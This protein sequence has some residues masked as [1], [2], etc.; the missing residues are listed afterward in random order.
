[1]D[2]NFNG[3]DDSHRISYAPN[4]TPRPSSARRRKRLS[5]LPNNVTIGAPRLMTQFSVKRRRLPTNSIPQS[6]PRPFRAASRLNSFDLASG[7]RRRITLQ[8]M[9]NGQMQQMPPFYPPSSSGRFFDDTAS[10]APPSSSSRPK[11]FSTIPGSQRIPDPRL[12]RGDRSYQAKMQK[13]LFDYLTANK[14]DIHMKQQL[15]AR[16]LRSPT[17]K[18]F[19]LMFQFL[20][21]RIDPGYRFVRSSE[22]DIYSILKFL[23]YPYLGNITKSQLGAV[24][25]T[26]WPTFLAMLHWIMQLVQQV[27]N[28]D[29]I[30][31][32]SLNLVPDVESPDQAGLSD[33]ESNNNSIVFSK[34]ETDPVILRENS[35]LDRLFTTFVINSYKSYLATGSTDYS[36]FYG[37]MEREYKKLT[38][39]IAAKAAHFNT[40]NKEL[41]VELSRMEE[42]HNRLQAKIDRMKALKIDVSK[43]QKYVESQ[44]QRSQQWPTILSRAQQDIDSVK[45]SIAEAKQEKDKIVADLGK[46]GFTLHEIEEMHKTRSH[47]SSEFESV[48]EKQRQLNV[49]VDEKHEKLQ[50]D[51]KILDELVKDYNKKMYDILDKSELPEI[52][53]LIITGFSDSL[54][55]DDSKL[56]LKPAELIPELENVDPRTVLA[57]LKTKLQEKHVENREEYVQIQEKFDDSNLEAV[58]LKDQLDELEDKLAKSRKDYDELNEQK[59]ADVASKQWEIE[60]QSTRIKSLQ[61]RLDEERKQTEAEYEKMKSQLKKLTVGLAEQRNKLLIEIANSIGYVISFKTGMMG[62]L[63]SANK[64]LI[65]ECKEQINNTK[66]DH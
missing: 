36:E 37:D 16:T 41:G 6:V 38:Q 66:A 29:K 15:T 45:K 46:K 40:K 56:G 53:K 10:M 63:E 17:Q 49:S 18:E 5:L 12:K 35:I 65:Q 33:N 28:F 52:R 9:S 20:Y 11:R 44:E 2:N 42:E 59:K 61:T 51:F 39:D 14:F 34:K 24:G 43:F 54:I 30:D 3:N 25:G 57:G 64:D 23:E 31:L 58:S 7:S 32:T 55:T 13:D 8:R 47:L 26:S 62:D 60:Q 27:E 48:T 21:K 22:Q 1:M 50:E 19:I 4:A